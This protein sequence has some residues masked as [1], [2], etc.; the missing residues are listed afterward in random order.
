MAKIFRTEVLA[1]GGDN[2]RLTASS[3]GKF[4]FKAVNANGTEGSDIFSN[5]SFASDI[6]GVNSNINDESTTR[7]N[8]VSSLNTQISTES[9]TRGTEVSSL[10]TLITDEVSD[11]EDAVEATEGLITAESTTRGN[12]VSSLNTL[13]STESSTRGTHVSSL[14]DLIST[15]N[16]HAMSVS[17]SQ[18]DESKTVDISAAG[19]SASDTVAVVATVRGTDA[20][21]PMVGCMLS[22]T[23]SHNSASFAFTDALPTSTYKLDL[24]ASV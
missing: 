14:A 10:N 21:D 8:D 18:G 17:L 9:S 23:A 15:E 1:V 6:A 5:D 24:L 11:R 4:A 16:V 20:D 22:G 3:D 7:G 2:I 13:I 12:Q 19:F